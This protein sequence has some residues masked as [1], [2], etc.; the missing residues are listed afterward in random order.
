MSKKKPEPKLLSGGNPQVP[1]ADGDEPVKTY[2]EAMPGWK[3]DVG[4]RLDSLLG[5]LPEIRRGVRWNQPFYGPQGSENW[6]LSFRCF[7]DYVQVQFLNG[8]SLDPMPPKDSKHEG[9]RYL[10][11][12][13]DD[14]LDEAQ[15]RSWFKQARELPPVKM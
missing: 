11:I 6:F 13:Q 10:D 12:R 2:V 15:L 8:T 14:E 9:M 4:R 5:E 3:R 1:K 7:T